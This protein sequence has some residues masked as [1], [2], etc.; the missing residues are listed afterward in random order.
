M[1][2]ACRME[3]C[4][5]KGVPAN[6]PCFSIAL[7]VVGRSLPWRNPGIVSC[8]CDLMALSLFCTIEQD[9]SGLCVCEHRLQV[10]WNPF[11]ASQDFGG[12]NILP[13]GPKLAGEEGRS[14]FVN[15]PVDETM[16][17]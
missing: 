13:K 7:I 12:V 2:V 17:E 10:C 6:V 11:L 15:D 9:T 16:Q 4:A 1:G 5:W 14:E 3:T 8:W